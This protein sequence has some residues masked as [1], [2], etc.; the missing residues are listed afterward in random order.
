VFGSAPEARQTARLD[1]MLARHRGTV[2]D[3]VLE[4]SD[5]LELEKIVRIAVERSFGYAAEF[6]R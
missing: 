6:R 5:F 3:R 1:I 2:G 4:V